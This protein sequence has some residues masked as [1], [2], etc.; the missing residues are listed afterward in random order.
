MI[1]TKKQPKNFRMCPPG[2]H[3]DE[4]YRAIMIRRGSRIR[5]SDNQRT[6]LKHR[7]GAWQTRYEQK[8]RY[9]S[10]NSERA[11]RVGG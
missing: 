1:I 3:H 9:R 4:P 5:C 10:E 7:R 2:R 6:A 11:R 8:N